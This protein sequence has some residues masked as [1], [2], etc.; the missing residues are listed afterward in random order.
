MKQSLFLTGLC[1]LI[2]A[3]CGGGGG[4]TANNTPTTTPASVSAT[5][6]S[7][8]G[9]AA[10]SSPSGTETFDLVAS[11]GDTWRF[12]V[13]TSTG[14][15]TVTPNNSQY[16][17]SSE[18]GTLTRTVSGDFV[19][20]SLANRV[21]LTQDTRTKSVS[22]SMTVGGQTAS[23]SGTQYQL[24]NSLASLAGTY[25]FLGSSRNRTASG[26][27]Y[28]PETLGG[29]M[30]VNADG[31]GKFCVNGKYVGSTCTSIGVS[32]NAPQE[33]NARF[34]KDTTTDGGF[35]KVEILS[36]VNNNWLNF[37]NLMIHPGDLGA[38]FMID[39]FGLND[40][41]VARVGN[42]FA[43]KAQTISAGT[44]MNGTWK[45]DTP[46]GIA[47]LTVNGTSS[48]INSP[49]ETPSTWTETLSFNKV[50]DLN[51][52]LIDLPGFGVTAAAD[53]AGTVFLPLSSSIAVIEHDSA[54]RV[55]LCYKSQ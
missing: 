37:G 34:T 3:G 29:Q 20:Y 2:L 10:I 55:G 31:T 46:N 28:W 35:V 53:G 36:S 8:L 30:L 33:A 49:N 5:T 48:T 19:T 50:N 26:G 43:V 6:A 4:G 40:E 7:T 38:A 13:N 23:V 41:N 45:C 15:F 44:V 9:A 14:A 11:I 47:T 16:S 51:N 27:N 18:T 54:S 24:G 52:A 25:N 22:G 32:Q 39:H 1:S 21:N 42:F 12:V 17:L